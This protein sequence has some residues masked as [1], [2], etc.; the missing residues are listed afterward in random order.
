[1]IDKIYIVHLPTLTDRRRYLDA[2]LPELGIPYEY[3]TRFD[4]SSWEIRDERYIDLSPWNMNRRNK[5]Y[6]ESLGEVIYSGATRDSWKACIMEHL[7]IFVDFSR[8][9]MES[10]LVLEDDALVNDMDR[11]KQH[12]ANIPEDSD[13]AYIGSGCSLATPSDAQGMWWKHPHRRS[14]CADSYIITKAVA[15]KVINS[16]LPLYCNW[17]WELNYQQNLHG[18]NVYWATNPSIKQGSEYGIY[19]PSHT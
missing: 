13:V 1:M 19:K 12:L 16:C 4:K 10:I 18:M 2:T 9:T 14:R 7:H 5:V 15:T 11:L 3:R 8:S 17:D 6:W